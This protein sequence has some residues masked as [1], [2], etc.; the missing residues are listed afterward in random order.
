M[1]AP[2]ALALFAG[3]VA[4]TNACTEQVRG[5]DNRDETAALAER[6][7][8]I[9]Q[10]L[11]SIGDSSIPIAR[12]MLPPQLKEISGLALKPNGELLAH[13]DERGS[14]FVI[15]PRKG[16]LLREFQLG[17]KAVH[18][19][20]EGITVVGSTIYMMTSHGRIFE[21][22]KEGKA[23]SEVEYRI[24]DTKLG[25]ECEFEGIAYDADSSWLVMPCK[26]VH[27]KSLKGSLVI[28]RYRLYGT[29]PDQDRLS[30]EAIPLREAIG[31][32]PWKHLR[33]SDI[34]IDPVTKNYVIITSQEHALIELTPHG[35][36]VRSMQLPRSL[37]QPEGVAISADNVLFVSDEG[38]K[39]P[40]SI[41]L[42]RWRSRGAVKPPADSALQKDSTTPPKS[43]T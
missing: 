9:A 32:N 7:A 34:T 3:A 13:N 16:V 37:R 26:V 25:N 43:S 42:F 40:A 30:V 36:V 5:K 12:W 41:S 29:A 27:K 23:G 35:E 1:K 22:P 14:V 11:A 39:T 10:Q 33:P 4:L 20:F 28:Y 15:D 24:H 17:T 31:N 2:L 8:R 6:E 19:D 38:V 18:A 21:I